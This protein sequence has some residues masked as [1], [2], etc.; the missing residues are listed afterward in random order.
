MFHVHKPGQARLSRTIAL[1][2]GLFL[3]AWGCK[4]LLLELSSYQTADRAR[5]LDR[6]WNEILSGAGPDARWTVDLVIL[7]SN[8]SPALTIAAVMF[9]VCGAW[10]YWLIN[11]PRVGDQ[12]I[13]MEAELR[14][15]SWPSFSDAWQ[16]TLV[17]S[18]FTAL[19]VVLVFTYDII[20]KRF[21]D[22][23]PANRMY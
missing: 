17:V 22:L 5:P 18:G 9:L 14:K 12:L 11:R 7:Q 8:F 2:G 13:D 6:S 4:A 23:M 10:W 16:S 15:V 1:L 21:I 20:I 19:I 3:A